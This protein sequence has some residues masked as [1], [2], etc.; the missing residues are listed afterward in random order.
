MPLFYKIMTYT[1]IYDNLK[2]TTE[3]GTL[4]GRNRLHSIH[5]EYFAQKNI[6]LTIQVLVWV[7]INI[8][9][10]VKRHSFIKY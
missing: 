1:W 4:E 10:I 3:R 2:L 7:E 8:Q 9:R 5:D 6:N